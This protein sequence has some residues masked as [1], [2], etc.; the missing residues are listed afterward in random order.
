MEGGYEAGGE[1]ISLIVIQIYYLTVSRP[2]LQQASVPHE[3]SSSACASRK[4]VIFIHLITH[5]SKH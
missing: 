5:T 3:Y 4:A 1:N 2:R